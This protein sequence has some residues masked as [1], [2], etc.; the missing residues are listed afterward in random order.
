MRRF[1]G[2]HWIIIL[3]CFFPLFIRLYLLHFNPDPRVISQA[4]SQYWARITVSTTRGTVEDTNGIPLALSS[5]AISFFIDPAVW[6]PANAKLL[7]PYVSNERYARLQTKLPGRYFSVARK[8]DTKKAEEIIALKIPGLFYIKETNRVYPQ[9]QTLSHVLGFCDIDEKGLAGLELSWD[10]LLYSPPQSR[11]FAKDASG[12][13]VDISPGDGLGASSETGV[14]RLT[15]DSRFQ[16]I[17]E[18]RVADAFGKHK[19]EWAAA[20]MVDPLSGEIQA[21]CSMPDFDPNRR[22]TFA[23]QEALLNN[24]IGRVYEPGSTFKPVIAGIALSN[25]ITNAR[26]RFDCKGKIRIADV[27][28]HDITSHGKLDFPGL[29]IESCNVGMASIGNRMDPHLTYS[30]LKQ[31]GFGSPLGVGL[32]G[33]EVGLLNPPDQWRGSVPANIAIGQGLGVTPLQMTMALSAVINGGHVM[34]PYIVREALSSDGKIVYK[35][36]PEKLFTVLS[37]KTSEYLKGV[38]E[39]VVTKGTGRTA[40][41]GNPRVG[42]KTGTAQVAQGGVYLKKTYVSSFVGFWPVERPRHLLFVAIGHPRGGEYLGG[43][44][45]APVF[46]KILEDVLKINS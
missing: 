19:A 41:L 9:G 23:Q 11:I 24:A 46:R 6:D 30:S 8:V 26:E 20:I 25:G 3:L 43:R 44:V 38:L 14:L 10:H 34:K 37:D 45:A 31:W 32:P 35:G 16:H 39:Q 18:K 33:E 21:M 28:I 29:L 27:V 1:P 40:F 22:E 12:N 15:I 7:K 4:K 5:P 13:I 2:F 36:N 42:G 17:V